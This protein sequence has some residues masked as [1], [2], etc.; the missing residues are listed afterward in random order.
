MHVCMLWVCMCN[1]SL[2]TDAVV[3]GRKDMIFLSLFPSLQTA[4]KWEE[5]TGS[6]RI[7]QQLEKACLLAP[8]THHTC[9]TAWSDTWKRNKFPFCLKHCDF[10]LKKK[11]TK[12][13]SPTYYEYR[14]D[15]FHWFSPQPGVI[16]DVI[17]IW[18]SW[19]NYITVTTSYFQLG[20]WV[21]PAQS[22]ARTES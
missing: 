13:F 6:A 15:S 2:F 16:P 1:G 5:G 20:R 8:Q 10:E 9:R 4:V 17:N 19:A 22:Q 3:S 7:E 21:L 11:K 14:A 12:N 18:N